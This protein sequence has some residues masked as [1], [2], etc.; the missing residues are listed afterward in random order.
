MLMTLEKVYRKACW[1][2]QREAQKFTIAITKALYQ[3]NPTVKQKTNS[4]T[5]DFLIAHY[6]TSAK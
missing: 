3:L 6:S 4:G 1:S 5:H 2:S